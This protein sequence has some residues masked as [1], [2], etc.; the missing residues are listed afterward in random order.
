MP[1]HVEFLCTW[2]RAR[3]VSGCTARISK[4]SVIG[5]LRSSPSVASSSM[6]TVSRVSCTNWQ[7][8]KHIHRQKLTRVLLEIKLA[9]NSNWRK[10]L[11]RNQPLSHWLRKTKFSSITTAL[12]KGNG[13]KAGLQPLLVLIVEVYAEVSTSW[14]CVE[15]MDQSSLNKPHAFQQ[16]HDT[17]WATGSAKLK[18]YVV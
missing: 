1:V 8:K 16:A 3:S 9:C 7:A 2:F 13:H 12:Q 11:D 15:C 17:K 14:C 6:A 18:Q 4:A 5:D 10:G